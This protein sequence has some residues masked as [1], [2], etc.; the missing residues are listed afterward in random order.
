M[1]FLI[2]SPQQWSETVFKHCKFGNRKLNKRLVKYASAQ[3]QSP[4]ASVHAVADGKRSHSVATYR[5]LGN[6]KVG[7]ED[8]LQ[9]VYE[10]TAELTSELTRFLLIEDTTELVFTRLQEIKT[11]KGG[12]NRPKTH[13]KVFHHTVIAVESE[14]Q[15]VLGLAYQHQWQRAKK[16]NAK[17][18]SRSE[19]R[20]RPYTEKESYKWE[21]V[22]RCMNELF[23]NQMENSISVCDREADIYEYLYYKVSQKQSFVVRTNQDRKL[24]K[25]EMRLFEYLPELPDLKN[26]FEVHIPQS[27]SR[28]ERNAELTLSAGKVVLTRDSKYEKLP[29]IE[30]N[31][32]WA[33]EE[34]A[35]K[36]IQALEW[37]LY[38][39]EQ[40]GTESEVLRVMGYYNARYL[41]EEYH[42][43]LKTGCK[44]EERALKDESVD[45]LLGILAPIAIRILQLRDLLRRN[46]K[47]HSSEF[48]DEFEIQVLQKLEIKRLSSPKMKKT[49][50][51]KGTP[52][53]PR[54]TAKPQQTIEWALKEIARLAGWQDT[55]KTGKVGWQ[56][57]WEGYCRFERMVE[58]LEMFMDTGD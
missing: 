49:T 39:S 2:K 50:R 11:K 46:P 33:R 8:I 32:V 35:P 10:Y 51:K 38:T 53:R 7:R 12:L 56:K 54:R 41:C 19:R 37:I 47:A 40:V 17:K 55:K 21:H 57:L 9:G 44:A 20:R 16:S 18:M 6:S 23:G 3:A 36:G 26:K 28:K 5:L 43:A 14:T 15:E 58:S 13:R 31:V 30:V 42:K 1:N 29:P 45:T 24:L 22:S 52:K 27:G 34:K 4:S 48:F 25:K